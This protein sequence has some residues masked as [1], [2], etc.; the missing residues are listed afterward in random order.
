MSDE[1]SALGN[2]L[3]TVDE[4]TILR[5]ASLSAKG[6]LDTQI[7]DIL[8]LTDHQLKALKTTDA[9]KLK[10]SEEA[11][12]AIERQFDLEEG[13]DS[14]EEEA[15]GIMLDT[16]RVVRDPKFALQVAAVANR[17]ERRAKNKDTAPKVVDGSNKTQNIVILNLNRNYINKSGDAK[18][19][20]VT[21]RPAQIP[22]K[23]SDVPAP[24][25]VDQILSD[26]EAFRTKEKP[27]AQQMEDDLAEMLQQ[28]GVIFDQS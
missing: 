19:I 10:Y 14:L 23:Q 21:A 5:A 24:K 26:G 15:L 20:D 28:S 9:F 8:L 7:V 3:E 25:L 11:T 12:K 18:T 17:A 27:V 13:W 1:N 6:M 16:M 4:H 22:L 2:I